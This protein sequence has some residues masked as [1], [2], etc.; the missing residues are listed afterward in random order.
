MVESLS[1]PKS[2]QVSSVPVSSLVTSWLPVT[3]ERLAAAQKA[4]KS[5]QKCFAAVVSEDKNSDIPYYYIDDGILMR[6]WSPPLAEKADWGVVAQIVVPACYR[7]HV[8][9]FAH[10]SRWA[11]HLGVHKTYNLVLKHF[12][13]PGLSDV[14][15]HCRTCHVCQL[16]GK[17]NQIIPPAPLHPIPA[18]GVPFER[19]IVDCVGPLPRTK[20]GNQYLLTIMCASTRFPEAMPLSNITARAVVRALTKFFSTFGMPKTVQTDQGTNFKSKLF[21][22]VLK[23]LDIQH[24]VSSAYHPE[25][26]G[27]LERWHQTLKSMLRK[28]CLETKVGMKA[29]LLFCSRLEKLFKIR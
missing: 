27:A 18:V 5:L 25:S 29:S 20:S 26:Q 17:P 22:Q 23:T 3:R 9:L 24:V 12:F 19:V 13:W 6:K 21:A 8:L 2:V 11:G 1:P 15:A 7:E 14:T 28:Y 10:E 16:A 4:D